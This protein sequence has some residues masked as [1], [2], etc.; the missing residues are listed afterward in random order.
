MT[1]SGG[2]RRCDVCREEATVT[3]HEPDPDNPGSWRWANY[4]AVHDLGPKEAT[5]KH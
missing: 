1:A 5:A 4:C 3:L 2:Q